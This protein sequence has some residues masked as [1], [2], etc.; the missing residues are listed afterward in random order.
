MRFSVATF[1]VVVVILALSNKEIVNGSNSTSDVS[2]EALTS[3]EATEETTEYHPS[4]SRRQ[5]RRGIAL[6]AT[7]IF[8]ALAQWIDK[9][10]LPGLIAKAKKLIKQFNA[11]R[12]FIKNQD[13]RVSKLNKVLNKIGSC[14]RFE[15][16][17]R[18]RVSDSKL[19]KLFIFDGP[20]P[21]YSCHCNMRGQMT[22]CRRCTVTE[23]NEADENYVVE[24][25]YRERYGMD[26]RGYRSVTKS[27]RKC[28][29]WTS[30]TYHHKEWIT[31]P[32]GEGHV[33]TIHKYYEHSK[34]A[35]V[36]EYENYCRNPSMDAQG[37]WCY[38]ED[39]NIKNETCGIPRCQDTVDQFRPDGRCGSRFTK[40][41]RPAQCRRNKETQCCN[42]QGFCS[43]SAPENCRCRTCIDFV[44]E[45][46]IDAATVVVIE[47][48]QNDP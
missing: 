7:R 14:G 3:N 37:P 13:T 34:W 15:R 28:M 41:G 10:R 18:V 39:E 30:G 6:A 9:L 8:K 5:S 11:Q 44:F 46:A 4:H 2:E 36:G 22:D 25:C 20:L 38:V 40:N 42:A 1:S 19:M 23:T 32:G 43:S 24:E 16:G 29:K 27:G 35:G 45:D 47:P 26:Y 12:K 21:C 33:T 31:L 48:A 17:K